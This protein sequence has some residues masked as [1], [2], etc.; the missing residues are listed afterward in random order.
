MSG[1]DN[2]A[3]ARGLASRTARLRRLRLR[4]E[5]I[6]IGALLFL[7]AVWRFT[8]Q[9]EPSAAKIG[10]GL[11]LLGSALAAAAALASGWHDAARGGRG[12][13]MI[14]CACA[15]WATFTMWSFIS[16][17]TRFVRPVSTSELSIAYLVMAL[18]LCAGII[19]LAQNVASPESIKQF[20]RDLIPA[21][22]ALATT[23][24]LLVV[25]PV[26]TAEH[27]AVVVKLS[28]FAHGLCSVGLIA[29]IVA[30][31]L[32]DGRPA[33]P[34][35][36]AISL[37]VGAFTI[38]DGLGMRAWSRGEATQS[39]FSD[40][41]WLAGFA[42][43][44][45][46]ARLA[47][48]Q[49]GD[50]VS[51]GDPL[52]KPTW[53]DQ[54]ANL[55]LVL[56]LTFAG[57]Q[58]ATHE[59]SPH[60]IDITIAASLAVLWFVIARSAWTFHNARRLKAEIGQLSTR[61]DGLIQEVGRDPL[62]GLVNRRLI[63]ERIDQELCC[64]RGLGLPLA[65][66]LI[67]LDNFKQINDTLGHDTGDRVICTVASILSANCRGGDVAARYAGDEFVL[68]LPGLAEADAAAVCS[69]I[70]DDLGQRKIDLAIGG[71]TPFGLSIGV[72]VTRHAR[73][74]AEHMLRI[75]DASMYDAKSAGKNRY[76]IVDADTLMPLNRDFAA[77]FP[78][79][80][81]AYVYRLGDRRSAREIDRVI[82]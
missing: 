59:F 74:S 6:T 26:L 30:V 60:G 14:T 70:I 35:I 9:T 78:K 69:R 75:A 55:S 37:A 72:A 52:E 79:L 39:A 13:R 25:G 49:R 4:L 29:A 17:A 19:L 68:L 82:G 31:L 16:K 40:L 48:G 1:T 58:E 47:F 20:R 71:D 42:L 57:I 44:A 63:H 38:A 34:V 32:I 7:F 15:A 61:L 18:M 10:L 43:I 77:E 28:T 50:E 22:V 36:S 45:F 3:S 2:L 46:A 80:S 56:L 64:A 21:V 67:D 5:G 23:F 62:T 11:G 24:W 81:A 12:W 54:T 76:E 53:H 65:V 51:A 41:L 8:A 33:P 73:R 66:A 27:V